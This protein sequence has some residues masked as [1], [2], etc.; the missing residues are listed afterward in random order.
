MSFA[1]F[2]VSRRRLKALA[3]STVSAAALVGVSISG[4]QAQDAPAASL[5]EI[6]VTGSRVVRDGYEAPTPVSVL[7]AQ[8]NRTPSTP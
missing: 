7:G 6:V 5:D 4:A 3:Y 8:E 2:S 1:Q